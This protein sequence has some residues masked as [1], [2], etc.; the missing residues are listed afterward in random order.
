MLV[1]EV[2][3]VREP[4]LRK[5]DKKR[6]TMFGTI[7]Q[8]YHVIK[9]RTKNECSRDF[10]RYCGIVGENV[11]LTLLAPFRNLSKSGCEQR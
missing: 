6:A 7:A 5:A 4:M 2:V 8:M 9:L 10:S 11:E 1:V 3:V